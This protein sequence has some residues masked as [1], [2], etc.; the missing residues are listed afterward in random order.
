MQCLQP[1]ARKEQ[2]SRTSI[3]YL[4]RNVPHLLTSE[5]IDR[6]GAEWRVYEMAD[7][8]EDWIKTSTGS[9]SNILEYVPIDKY[10]YHIFSTTTTIGTPQ[11]VTLTKLIKCLLSL[12]HGNSDVERGFSQNN[13]LVSNERSSLNESSINGLRATNDGVK[14]FG[15]GKVHMVN[16]HLI[17]SKSYNCVYKVP[18]TNALISN[19]QEAHSRYV[20]YNA[21][22]QKLMKTIDAV[23]GKRAAEAEHESMEENEIE[24]L[25]KQKH[26][27]QELVN[28]TKMLEEGSTR[29]ATALSSKAFDDVGTAEVLIAAAN[30]K[31]TVLNTQLIENNES[32]NRM[33]KKQKK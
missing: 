21:E 13:H 18:T 32:L 12:S 2:T 22:Q 1:S 30:A 15:G 20:K 6:V 29:L 33:R 26:L 5:E 9:S 27:Q 31:L 28:A 8:P 7:I 10:W 23:N 3:I 16:T 24:L 4:A 11:Y 17:Y 19:V 25:N 14:F